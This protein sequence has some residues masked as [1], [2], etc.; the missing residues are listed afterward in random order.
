MS[1]RRTSR[2][3]PTR[4]ETRERILTAAI[5][6]FA[7]KGP[8]STSLDDIAGHAG[9]TKGAVYSSF[10]SKDELFVAAVE[11]LPYATLASMIPPGGSTPEE[12]AKA[13][14][15]FGEFVARFQPPDASIAFLHEMYAYALR[16]ETSRPALAAWVAGIFDASAEATGDRLTG[17]GV[18]LK[19]SVKEAWIIGQ[20][21]LEGMFLRR[22]L[23]PEL[24]DDELMATA[25]A[26][27]GGLAVEPPPKRNA[28]KPR[29]RS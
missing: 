6:L 11:R 1:T 27:L 7:E 15:T 16:N 17:G 29:R 9:L 14:R 24:V 3:R 23:N 4:A 22:A 28:S 19:V 26:L 21:I 2:T 12:F 5:E 18:Q 20:A 13:M 8:A 25:I 10:A